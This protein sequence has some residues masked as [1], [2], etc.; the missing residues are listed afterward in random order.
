VRSSSSTLSWKR[1]RYSTLTPQ[2]REQAILQIGALRSLDSCTGRYRSEAH[3][4]V[5]DNSTVELHERLMGESEAT[6]NHTVRDVGA[7]GITQ[8]LGF[9]L[10]NVKKEHLCCRT[11]RILWEGDEEGGE[12]VLLGCINIHCFAPLCLLR[13][14]H[15]KPIFVTRY[16]IKDINVRMASSFVHYGIADNSSPETISRP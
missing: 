8:S 14:G 15:R 2:S 5:V 4:S 10:G 16:R 1:P 3:G 12:G 9:T 7:H 13:S 11:K 6:W